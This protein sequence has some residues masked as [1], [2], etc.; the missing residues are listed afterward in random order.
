MEELRIYNKLKADRNNFETYWQQVADFIFPKRDFTVQRMPGSDRNARIYDSTGIYAAQALASSL[1][2]MLTPPNSKW[3]ELTASADYTEEEKAWLDVS[4]NAV[5]N[6]LNNPQTGFNSQIHEVYLDLVAFGNGVLFVDRVDGR[7]RFRARDLKECY[8]IEN[9]FGIVDT[10]Y[11][12]TEM[13]IRDAIDFFPS[14]PQ[15]HRQK[16]EADPMAKMKVLHCV[17][18]R[19]GKRTQRGAAKTLKPFYS[20]YIDMAE[21][22]VLM[23]GGYDDMPYICPRFSKRAGESYGFGPAMMALPAVKSLNTLKG[24]II[25][26][27]SKQIDPPMYV[28]DDSVRLP[29]R[30]DP[31]T[32]T[33]GRPDAP[34]PAP[35]ITNPRPDFGFQI[36]Q[37]EQA[38]IAKL[39]SVDWLNLPN[40]RAMTA[41]EVLQRQQE[42]MRL[43][44]PMLSRLEAELQEQLVNR[45]L[46]LL[47]EG[48]ELPP[49]P[50]S[51]QGTTVKL[52]FISPL[53]QAQKATEANSVIQT[54]NLVGQIAAANPAVL[55]NFNW[56]IISR[57]TSVNIYDLP[58]RYLVP[59]QAVQEGRQAQAEQAQIAQGAQVAEQYA[60]AARNV[61]SAQKFSAQADRV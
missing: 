27:Y 26:G 60:A 21:K 2:S 20:K 30:T 10:V 51:L 57:E 1:H 14:V 28:V 12:C 18:P 3:L 6:V 50:E 37:A 41:T 4:E 33:F 29:L 7:I 46:T 47:I 56:D 31:G 22:E 58:A 17:G 5:M 36:L 34:A 55:E 44:S 11:R 35:L 43:L 42:R 40:E 49:P 23:E 24:I 15:S 13:L 38:D 9:D 59:P 45:I 53:V 25:R 54:I 61:A 48:G 32:I 39:F 8:F 52:R 19:R 16:Y